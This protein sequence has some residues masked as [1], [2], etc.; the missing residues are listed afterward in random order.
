MEKAWPVY[1]GGGGE[2]VAAIHRLEIAWTNKQNISES[3]NE[4]AI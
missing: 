1:R 3:G 2:E 4:F